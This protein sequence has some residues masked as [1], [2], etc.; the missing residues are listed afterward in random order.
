MTGFFLWGWGIG[1]GILRTWGCSAGTLRGETL[2]RCGETQERWHEA[3]ATWAAMRGRIEEGFLTAR[4]S[5]GMTGFFW[6]GWG[7]EIWDF[8]DMG[9]SSAAT[10]RGETLERWHE[11]SAT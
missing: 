9:G 6:W 2:E 1:F 10:L 4:T 3:S 11:A 7:I 5:F 8:A